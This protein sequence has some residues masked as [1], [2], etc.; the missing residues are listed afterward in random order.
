MCCVQLQGSCNGTPPNAP[1]PPPASSWNHRRRC[2]CRRRRYPFNPPTEQFSFAVF[3]QAFCAVQSCVVH[4]QG[5]PLSKRF[6][7]VPLG[8]P[9]LTYSSTAKAML[10]YDPA[11]HEVRLEV[12]RAYAPGEPVKAWCG[13]QPNSKLLINYG[14]VDEDNPY[15]KLPLAGASMAV[16]ADGGGGGGGGPLRGVMWARVW[17]AWHA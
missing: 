17:T 6:A 5:V 14:I 9:L 1:P 13:P 2:F 3:K 7:L 16:V 10:R 8:P 11:A 4:L 15:D 12:E